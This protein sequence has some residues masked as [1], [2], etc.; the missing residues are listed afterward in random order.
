MSNK[1]KITLKILVVIIVAMVIV[2]GIYRR[3]YLAQAIPVYIQYLEQRSKWEEV[4][5]G[6]YMYIDFPSQNYKFIQ[7]NKLVKAYRAWS[8]WQLKGIISKEEFIR[9]YHILNEELTLDDRFDDIRA[10]LWEKLWDKTPFRSSNKSDDY[11]IT[12]NY[13]KKYGYPI[14]ISYIYNGKEFNI[15]G[16]NWGVSSARLTMFPKNT[17]YTDKLLKKLIEKYKKYYRK[18][19]PDLEIIEEVGGSTIKGGVFEEIKAP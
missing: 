2:F 11:S 3:K 7:N 10:I 12:I 18:P 13:N 5:S 14:H 16:N 4:N 19:F 1:I 6:T 8:G 9:R 17:E 15:H